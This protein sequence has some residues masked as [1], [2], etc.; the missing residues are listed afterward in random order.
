MKKEVSNIFKGA[1]L[2]NEDAPKSWLMILFVSVLAIVMIA[3]SHSAD[4]KVHQIARINNEAKELRSAFVDGRKRLTE[5]KK[6]TVV[7]LK[8]ER[9]GL[10]I[11]EIPPTKIKVKSQR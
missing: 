1:F 6:E 11:S 2:V 4:K 5:L 8:M 10:A 7:E 3:S 9:R